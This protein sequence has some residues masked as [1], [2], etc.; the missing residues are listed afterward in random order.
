MTGIVIDALLAVMV[1]SAW[2]GCAGFARL[3]EPLDRIHCVAFVNATAGA[4]LVIAG[5]VADGPSDRAFKILLV[6]GASLLGGAAMSHAT[7]RAL[8]E[9]GSAPA[10][11]E[12]EAANHA[13]ERE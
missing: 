2:L 5:F 12:R 1:L 6:V 4:A 7:G 11:I 9:R 8:L 13:G 10:A 3:R